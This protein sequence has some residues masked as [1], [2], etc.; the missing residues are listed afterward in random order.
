MSNPNRTLAELTTTADMSPLIPRDVYARAVF[1]AMYAKRVLGQLAAAMRVD[2]K[3]GEGN[4]VK[5]RKRNKRAAQ[6][7]IAEMACLVPNPQGAAVVPITI[8]KFG[9]YD[10]IS[11][12][13]LEQTPDDVKGQLL[14]DMGSAI[15]EKLEQLVYDMLRTAAGTGTVNLDVPGVIDYQEILKAEAAFPVGY[16]ADVLIISKTHKA[17]L[18][19]DPA[20]TKTVDYAADG[21]PVL[22]GEVGRVGNI[23]I[24]VHD[25][26]LPKT[27]AA[28]AIQGIMLDSRLA[29][30][31]AFGKPL[32][33]HEQYVPECDYY[34][35]VAWAWYGAAILDAAAIVKLANA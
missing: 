22:P 7:P 21:V 9:D 33:F 34:K 6:G 8:Q 26:A 17:D 3:A 27:G 12:E 14:D 25:L 18:L 24:L 11:D 31:E 35:E 32:R 4:T 20:I 29:F 15:D 19:L 10:Q 28:A 5:V 1:T 13:A 23:R 16:R 2:I 30:G